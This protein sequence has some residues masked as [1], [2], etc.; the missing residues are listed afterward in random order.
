MRYLQS[1]HR[2]LRQL[3]EA[4]RLSCEDVAQMCGV[5]EQRVRSWEADEVRHRSY[6]GVTELLDLCLKT[7][8]PLENLV[9]LELPDGGGQ[10]EL[11]GLAFSQA[12]DLSEALK[13]L[14]QQLDRVQLSDSERE[15]LRR[16]R[17]TSPD[18]RRM[19]LQLLGG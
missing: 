8:T 12:D 19:V 17:K 14:E 11:P 9:D 15:L 4:G 6:P 7:E 2:R 5:D 10:L 13:E 18:N 1:F 3:R 16:F